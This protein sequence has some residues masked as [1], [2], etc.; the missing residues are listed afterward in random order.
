MKTPI[1]IIDLIKYSLTSLVFAYFLFPIV[2]KILEWKQILDTPD[3]RKIHHVRTP[4]MGGIPI[5]IGVAFSLLLWLPGSHGE[6]NKYLFSSLSLF[7]I[8]GLRDDLIPMQP[9]LK[10]LSQLIPIVIIV[11]LADLRL[12]SF[13]DISNFQFNPIMSIVITIFSLIVITNSFNLIDGIDGLAGT[14]SIIALTSFGI[15]FYLTGNYTLS[16]ITSAF[17]GSIISFLIYNWSPSKIFMGD[18]GALLIGFFLACITIYFINLNFGLESTS[19]YKFEASISTA[20]CFIIVPLV[21]T[22]R[23]FVIRLTHFKSPFHADNNHIHHILIQVGL[24]HST[25]TIVLATINILFIV[26]AYFGRHYSDKIML[27]I[28][29][30]I[31]ILLL[32]ALRWFQLSIKSQTKKTTIK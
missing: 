2:I 7:F 24:S 18:T 13:Y 11:I 20:I 27:L 29:F 5:F 16:F 14:I 28:I 15:W 8:I 30:G 1:D 3:S 17:V 22:L 12:F 25:A 4:S 26:L 32:V 6:I 31:V 21:D 19:P 23:V 9:K 10:L